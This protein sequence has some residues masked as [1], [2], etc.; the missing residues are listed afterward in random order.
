MSTRS[1]WSL[2]TILGLVTVI[3]FVT[4]NLTWFSITVVGFVACLFI[5]MGIMCITPTLVGPHA[6]E[7]QHG[8]AEPIQEKKVQV[9]QIPELVAMNVGHAR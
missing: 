1:Y 9:Q 3:L 7:F 6:Q 2:W 4:A 5:F 8:D